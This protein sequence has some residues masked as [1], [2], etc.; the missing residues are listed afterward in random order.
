MNP[1]DEDEQVD[2]FEDDMPEDEEAIDLPIPTFPTT[3]TIQG[4]VATFVAVDELMVEA[5]IAQVWDEYEGDAEYDE[6]EEDGYG[7]DME[8]LT[9]ETIDVQEGGAYFKTFHQL[10]LE[11]TSASADHILDMIPNNN[12][13]EWNLNGYNSPVRTSASR[14]TLSYLDAL[15]DAAYRGIIGNIINPKMWKDQETRFGEPAANALPLEVALDLI[16][17]NAQREHVRDVATEFFGLPIDALTM[18]TLDMKSLEAMSIIPNF[19]I[20]SPHSLGQRVIDVNRIA[21]DPTFEGITDAL[22][23]HLEHVNRMGD[24]DEGQLNEFNLF[25]HAFS[26]SMVYGYIYLVD[27]GDEY[28]TFIARSKN[29]PV[30]N[31]ELA[32][33]PDAMVEFVQ[34]KSHLVRDATI[35]NAQYSASHG[36][37][38]KSI[39]TALV[40]LV[41]LA[42][43]EV[44]AGRKEEAY[45]MDMTMLRT[46]I[47]QAANQSNN[48]FGWS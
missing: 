11:I 6:P 3:T 16:E 28:C 18:V 40:D 5:T 8:A 38:V 39:E 36:I 2:L 27:L 15:V 4:Q 33:F 10:M 20:L 21:H 24:L 45:K 44:Y 19:T 17:D 42:L 47:K 26:A 14:F 12:E 46:Q 41:L 43:E 34:N 37:L 23:L 48:A 1:E 32:A 9:S 7:H 30:Q 22:G 13:H 31:V 35:F 25:V 29:E